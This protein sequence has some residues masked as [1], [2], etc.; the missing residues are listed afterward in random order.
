VLAEDE[1]L[2]SRRA[3]SSECIS[4]TLSLSV[5]RAPTHFT[6][7]AWSATWFGLALKGAPFQPVGR[8]DGC[9][10][11]FYSCATEAGVAEGEAT[12]LPLAAG[13]VLDDELPQPASRMTP[14][15]TAQT[16]AR[17]LYVM[18]RT[19][20]CGQGPEGFT[21]ERYYG[22]VAGSH[23]LTWRPLELNV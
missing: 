13:V 2:A 15:P 9:S 3:K 17:S 10:T 20:A 14:H 8:S 22:I 6:K 11:I 7:D 12:G 21:S 18:I 19:L 4:A 1:I 16:R 5:L 23:S